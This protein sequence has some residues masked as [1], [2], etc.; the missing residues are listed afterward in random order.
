MIDLTEIIIAL[1]GL[2]ATALTTF[3]IP[4]LRQKMSAE[5]FSEMQMWVNI[6]VKAA[7]ML[8]TGTG[9]GEEKKAYVTEFLN[10]KGYTLDATSIENMIEAA[11]LEMQNSM[12]Q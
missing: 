6:A 3:L 12:A 11:V 2:V 5:K 8:Y 9:R 4:Y 7:E 10:S 1:I